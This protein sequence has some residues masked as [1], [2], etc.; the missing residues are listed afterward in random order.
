MTNFFED[1]IDVM[2]A[3]VEVIGGVII[4]VKAIEKLTSEEF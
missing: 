3:V 4:A 1:A 2:Q